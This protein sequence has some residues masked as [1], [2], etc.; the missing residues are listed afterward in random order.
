MSMK[1]KV[2][3]MIAEANT[4]TG[5]SDTNLT[6]AVATLIDGYGGSTPT[7]TINITDTSLTDVTNYAN[8]QVVDSNLVAGNIKKDV[9]ILGVTGTFEG[10]GATEPYTEE[11]YDASGNLT[12]VV[13]HG[14]IYITT[15]RFYKCSALTSVVLSDVLESIGAHAFEETTALASIS[16]P[17][18]LSVIGDSAFFDSNKFTSIQI[19]ANVAEIK[20]AA[21]RGCSR[22]TYVYFYGTPD[23][24]A[25]NAFYLDTR[26]TNV[27]VPWADGEVAGAPWGATN[28]QIHYSWTPTA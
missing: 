21:F 14:N 11:T 5:E 7:G 13:M 3:N 27:Y 12:S 25:T 18:S 17:N 6:D 23:T 19:P 15:Y 2:L 9:N 8:A 16:F 24:I 28:A 20:S 22:L 10:G 4:T 1:Q 26:I